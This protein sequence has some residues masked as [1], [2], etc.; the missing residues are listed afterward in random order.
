MSEQGT[1]PP[2]TSAAPTMP[3]PPIQ[4]YPALRVIASIYR[5]LAYVA[6]VGGLIGVIVGFGMLSHS[7]TY[8]FGSTGGIEVVLLSIICGVVGFISFLAHSEMILVSIDMEANTRG[9]SI[10]LRTIL[11]RSSKR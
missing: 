10:L 5:V 1:V 2:Q 11:E 4:K 8:P 3:G 7:G 9:T 6:L